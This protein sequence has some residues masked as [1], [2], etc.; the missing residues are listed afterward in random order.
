MI[1]IP[2]R[3]TFH[4]IDSITCTQKYIKTDLANPGKMED[5]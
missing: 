2:L 1:L 4:T 5:L 3:I